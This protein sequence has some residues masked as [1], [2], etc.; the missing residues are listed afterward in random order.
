MLISV[1]E[2]TAT[3]GQQQVLADGRNTWDARAQVIIDWYERAY[4]Q[5]VE[6]VTSSAAPVDELD[7]PSASQPKVHK[8]KV[9]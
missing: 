7:N 2:F 8:G 1:G 9:Q 4:P 6:R 5:P 3:L